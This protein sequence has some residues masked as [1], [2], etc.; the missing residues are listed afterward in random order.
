MVLEEGAWKLWY[1]GRSFLR[2]VDS[3]MVFGLGGLVVVAVMDS[4]DRS[5]FW[6]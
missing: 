2:E 5:V 4:M 1:C 6:C 3:L